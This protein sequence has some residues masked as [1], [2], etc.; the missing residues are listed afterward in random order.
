MAS[1]VTSPDDPWEA[2]ANAGF[3]VGLVRKS[4][5]YWV[6]RITSDLGRD[7]EH[8]TYHTGRG[9]TAVEA[10]QSCVAWAASLGLATLTAAPVAQGSEQVTHNGS[11]A[12]SSPARRTPGI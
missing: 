12:G 9:R 3:Y 7:V 11:D 10:A 8:D 2:L 5:D 6:V 4:G 1:S